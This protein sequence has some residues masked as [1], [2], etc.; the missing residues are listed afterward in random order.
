MITTDSGV[1]TGLEMT[2]GADFSGSD[3]NKVSIFSPGCRSTPRP[4]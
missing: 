2:F 3:N 4:A 1:V